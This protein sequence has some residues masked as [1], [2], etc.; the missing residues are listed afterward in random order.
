MWCADPVLR[1]SL[2]DK[3]VCTSTDI[4]FW[5]CTCLSVCLSA[6]NMHAVPRDESEAD[7]E[8]E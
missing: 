6:C 2:C 1:T 8:G 4:Y 5:K 3:Y 7:G